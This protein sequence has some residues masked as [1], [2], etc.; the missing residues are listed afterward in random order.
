MIVVSGRVVQDW[1]GEEGGSGGSSSVG[2]VLLVMRTSSE[3]S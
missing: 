1:T 3:I 2:Y